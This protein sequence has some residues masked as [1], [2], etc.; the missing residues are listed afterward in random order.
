LSLSPVP[1]ESFNNTVIAEA[2]GRL[3]L[4][5]P[6]IG[7]RTFSTHLRA[8][9]VSTGNFIATFPQSVVQFYAARYSLKVLPVELPRPPWPVQF[10]H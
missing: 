5:M 6:K 7:L 1:N 4:P 2:C 3:D 9:L 10:R 8:S